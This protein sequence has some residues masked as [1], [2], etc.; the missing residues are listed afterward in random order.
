MGA[1]DE[2]QNANPARI[3]YELYAKLLDMLVQHWLL[4]LSCWDDPHR[5]LVGAAQVIRDQVPTMVH[6]LT[7]RLPLSKTLTNLFRGS[8]ECAEVTWRFMGLSIAEWSLL[9]FVLFGILSLW[10]VF[11]RRR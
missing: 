8:G 1:I 10:A 9:W 4:L 6:A 2:W 11:R 3:L 5:S 7:S